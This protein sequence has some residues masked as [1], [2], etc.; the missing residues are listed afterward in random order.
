VHGHSSF[1]GKFSPE[2]ES[3]WENREAGEKR[4]GSMEAAAK[5]S[6][7]DLTETSREGVSDESRVSIYS[8]NAPK[9]HVFSKNV[10]PMIFSSSFS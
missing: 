2:S 4:A 8:R 9:S 7:E 10:V 3:S 6:F 1:H 5:G